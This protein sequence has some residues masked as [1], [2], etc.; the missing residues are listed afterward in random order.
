MALY[1]ICYDDSAETNPP[2]K[3]VTPCTTVFDFVPFEV[4]HVCTTLCANCVARDNLQHGPQQ[5]A[6]GAV[7]RGRKPGPILDNS[8][9]HDPIFSIT[10]STALFIFASSTSR[11]RFVL[12]EQCGPTRHFCS[13]LGA[14]P[15]L[16]QLKPDPMGRVGK[17]L[18]R[19]V[20]VPHGESSNQCMATRRSCIG[21]HKDYT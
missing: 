9:R 2:I 3:F 13:G 1:A 14:S 19:Y 10:T 4:R 11:Q 20:V 7:Y 16:E 21:Q 17:T 8:T 5:R 15:Y 6:G 18:A 12:L